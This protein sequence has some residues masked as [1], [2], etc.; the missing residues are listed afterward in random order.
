MK[1]TDARHLEVKTKN[2][3]EAQTLEEAQEIG[4]FWMQKCKIRDLEKKGLIGWLLDR[5]INP[6]LDELLKKMNQIS[7][8]EVDEWEKREQSKKTST[9]S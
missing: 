8:K 9:D 3:Y 2:P 6:S 1:I 7:A 4:F 5:G